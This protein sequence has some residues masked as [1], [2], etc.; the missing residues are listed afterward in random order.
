MGQRDGLPAILV[1]GHLGDDLGGD[2]AGGGEAVGPLDHGAGDH[3]AVLQHIL[4]VHQVA[5][6]HML[7]IIIRI[8]E[9]DDA[10]LMGLHDVPVAAAARHPVHLAGHVVPLGGVHHRVLIGVLLASSLQHSIRLRIF[11]SVVLLWRTNERV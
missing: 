8:M 10:L 3:S 5:V 6:V 4:Q 11:S 2:V 7:G 9:V 1:R